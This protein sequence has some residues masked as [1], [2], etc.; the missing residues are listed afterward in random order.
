MNDTIKF[1]ENILNEI[2]KKLNN[3]RFFLRVL[4][5]FII[6]FLIIFLLLS[7]IS[8]LFLYFSGNQI[9]YYIKNK[10][11][12][13]LETNKKDNILD[14]LHL[15]TVNNLMA[16]ILANIGGVIGIF[17]IIILSLQL[18][19]LKINKMKLNDHKS[20]I[21]FIFILILLISIIYIFIVINQLNIP[22]K[23]DNVNMKFK[24]LNTNNKNLF[25]KFVIFDK[26][27]NYDSLLSANFSGIFNSGNYQIVSLSSIICLVS[28]YLLFLGYFASY[29]F[30]SVKNRKYFD[31]VIQP[32]FDIKNTD[33]IKEISKVKEIKNDDVKIPYF[34][35]QQQYFLE[36]KNKYKKIPHNI[37]F[38]Q[39]IDFNNKESKKIIL[40]ET[41]DKNNIVPN[42]NKK[43]LEKIKNKRKIDDLFLK[44]I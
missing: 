41:E 30:I 25:I 2:D 24:Y 17:L 42:P 39:E 22:I 6:P 1:S 40:I 16:I 32:V 44:E 10:D 19:Y 9:I 35:Q 43:G 34:I 14:Y 21:S 4:D 27:E 36:N 5:N 11:Y 28:V 38:T 23:I 7:S 3:K 15:I 31:Q 20:I 37:S 8:F 26:G 29:F 12:L 13:E 18:G 33:K